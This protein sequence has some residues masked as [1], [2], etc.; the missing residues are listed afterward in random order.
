MDFE[1]DAFISVVGK[2]EILQSYDQTDLG[3]D[4][5]AHRWRAWWLQGYS[6][7]PV[8]GIELRAYPVTRLTPVGA[9]IDTDAFREATKQPWE[10]G[11]PGLAWT[12]ADWHKTRWVSDTSG[13]AWAKPTREA[14][15]YSLAK[16]L[17]RWA[18]NIAII[19]WNM[20]IANTVMRFSEETG[21]SQSP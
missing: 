19:F 14:A 8:D 15:I 4:P 20:R 10:E 13:A 5:S 16:R 12:K 6:D 17:D 3:D 1:L 11:A 2:R 21:V 7:L 18:T 9:W